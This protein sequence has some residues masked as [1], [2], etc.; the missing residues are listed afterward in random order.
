MIEDG[1]WLGRKNGQ[2]G[3]FPSNFVQELDR[4]PPGRRDPGPFTEDEGW[5]EGECGGKRGLFPDNFVILLQPLVPKVSAGVGPPCLG[6]AG[7]GGPVSSPVWGG[8]R[9]RSDTGSSQSLG[10]MAPGPIA[11]GEGTAAFWVPPAGGAVTPR[12]HPRV[13]HA[14]PLAQLGRVAGRDQGMRAG[15]R[16]PSP[17]LG[18]GRLDTQALGLDEEIRMASLQ[19]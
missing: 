7:V 10:Q 15:A 6:L 5:W 17:S 2:V 12:E 13:V 14:R 8:G 16:S 4:L 18:R 1:W 19:L 3:A 9:R 11:V